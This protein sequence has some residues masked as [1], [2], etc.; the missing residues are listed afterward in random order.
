MDIVFKTRKSKRVLAGIALVSLALL[1]GC[2]TS[3]MSTVYY[4]VPG[5]TVE[6]ITEQI[7]RRGPQNG[8]AIG[9]T[10]TRMTPKIGTVYNNGQCSIISADVQLSMRITLP[11][12]TELH[13][14]DQRTVT[15][16]EA[17][18][19]HVKWH[20]QQHVNISNR[21]V[22]I[23][24]ERLLS[25]PPQKSCR[26]ILDMA[27]DVF[28]AGFKEHNKAQLAFD[29]SERDAIRQR[30]EGLQDLKELPPYPTDAT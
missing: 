24:E 6:Q 23:I 10:E 5:T 22:D 9:T 2:T 14:A 19:D 3:G 20:E 8:H 27:R 28:T 26:R 18:G 30:L 29:E 4:K 15:V 21:Y 7:S 16:F 13:K 1:A 12:W 17:L 11:K 25:I